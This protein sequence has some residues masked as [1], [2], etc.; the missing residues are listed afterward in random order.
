MWTY[1]RTDELYH[2]GILGM[3][4]GV[5]RYQSKN[6]SLT[7]LG[8]RRA[9]QKGWSQDAKEAERL[10]KKGVKRL[11]NDEVKRLNNR[12]NLE[13]TYKQNNQHPIVKGA[14]AT[15]TAVATIGGIVALADHI[16]KSGRLIKMGKKAATS[17]VRTGKYVTLKAIRKLKGR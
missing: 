6:G 14:K 9:K 10:R 4:W 8:K 2:H 17:T 16:T 11:T 1:Q 5:R 13:R 7:P 12:Q 3:K 15:A